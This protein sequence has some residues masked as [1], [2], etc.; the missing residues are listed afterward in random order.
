MA[1]I[2]AF[3]AV[4]PKKELSARIASLPYDVYN[5]KEARAQVEK[6]PMGFLKIDRAESLLDENTDIYAKEVYE[7]ARSTYEEMKNVGEF[8]QDEKEAYYLYELTMEGRSQTGLVACASVDDYLQGVI[9]KHENTRAEKEEDRVR[10][11]DTMS[12]QTGPIFLAYRAEERIRLLFERIKER[13]VLFDFTKEGNIR[14]RGWM[15]SDREEIAEI[16]A[17]FEKIPNT[18]I[19]DGHHRAASAI[20]V[21]KMRREKNPGYTGK[22]EFNY[23]LSV[24]F[25][26]EELQILDYNRVLKDWNGMTAE[27]FLAGLKEKFEVQPEESPVRPQKKGEFGLYL[28]GSWYRL[29]VKPELLKEDPVEGLDVSLLQREVL[30][31]FFG[32]Q[33]PRTDERIDFVGGIR[34]LKELE[35]RVKE[36]AVA[37]FSLYPTSLSELFHVAD[38]NKLMPPK[39]TWFEPKLLSGLFIHEI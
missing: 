5:R 1:N 2:K 20:R 3:Q 33:D 8:V 36:D 24:L 21:A 16:T 14:H 35:R 7:K 9:K 27:S 4:R 31:P 22:E 37:A 12:A 19:A 10:H 34:G 15:I 25:P 26:D 30:T 23:F 29:R 6:E 17:M 38:E 39:S 18:Y 11:V 13:P 32:I 28:P